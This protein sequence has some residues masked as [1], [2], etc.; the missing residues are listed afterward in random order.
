MDR[1]L[2]QWKNSSGCPDYTAVSWV[3]QYLKNDGYPS[4][5]LAHKGWTTCRFLIRI[6]S[7][8]SSAKELRDASLILSVMS[9]IIIKNRSG[10]ILI[11]VASQISPIPFLQVNYLLLVLWNHPNRDKNFPTNSMILKFYWW[12]VVVH[13][14]KH[15]PDKPDKPLIV[16]W[17]QIMGLVY[18]K[19]GTSAKGLLILLQ[20][21]GNLTSE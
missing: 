21:A 13:L 15:M 1:Q 8:V 16:R 19:A 11:H 10:P 20:G 5:H 17:S 2:S 3:C 4:V 12:N 7:L 6:Q 14:V 18:S 9:S